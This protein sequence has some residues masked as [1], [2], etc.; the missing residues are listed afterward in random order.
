MQCVVKQTHRKI[1]FRF[2]WRGTHDEM[3]KPIA[4]KYWKLFGDLFTASGFD[5]FN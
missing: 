1:V 3:I 2:V 4:A 5:V